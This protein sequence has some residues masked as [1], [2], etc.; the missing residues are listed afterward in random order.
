MDGLMGRLSVTVFNFQSIAGLTILFN[1]LADS[2]SFD[3][4][5]LA[6][7]FTIETS[8]ADTLVGVGGSTVRLSSVAF[9]QLTNSNFTFLNGGVVRLDAAGNQSLLGTGA[10]DYFD[11]RKGGADMVNGGAGA[12]RIFAGTQLSQSDRI[13]G[14]A[15][16]G[17]VDELI[18][19]GVYGADVVFLAN[20]VTSVEIIRAE[21][22]SRIRLVL[23]ANTVA[24]ASGFSVDASAQGHAD[25]L[26][27]IGTAATIGFVATGGAG[28]DSIVGGSGND[29]LTGG[30]G[31]DS[32]AGGGNDTIVGGLGADSLSGGAGG[33]RDTLSGGEADDKISGGAN[34]DWLNGDNGNDTRNVEQR[35]SC[36]P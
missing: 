34:E 30:L 3:A 27:L 19:T 9:A 26:Q 31:D 28:N 25:Q 23:D 15:S 18:V 6:S 7:A 11:I 20:T 35:T 2:I 24:S 14:G 21:A 33:D 10:D 32:I 5:Y 13:S 1:P 8:G 12:D 36:R 16:A 22:G 29:L 17:T 4:I